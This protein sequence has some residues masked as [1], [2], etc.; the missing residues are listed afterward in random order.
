MGPGTGG[1]PLPPPPSASL[2]RKEERALRFSH[3]GERYLL[4]YGRDFF[5]IWE[6][7]RPEEPIRRFPRSDEGWREAWAAYVAIEPH[8]AAV[9]TPAAPPLRGGEPLPAPRVN[10]AWWLLPIL[11]GWVGGLI[12]YFV[13]RE[14]DP[15]AARAMLVVGIAL[16]LLGVMLLASLPATR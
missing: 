13:N 9:D 11:L 1:L 2:P 4:G 7:A 14:T 6:R 16:S 10:G 5:G 15:A 8:P 3:S 12:A